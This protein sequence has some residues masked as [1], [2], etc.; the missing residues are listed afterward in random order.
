MEM[1]RMGRSSRNGKLRRSKQTVNGSFAVQDPRHHE[2]IHLRSHLREYYPGF[3]AAFAGAKGGV[4]RPEARA[5]LAAAPAPAD[6]AKLTLAQ[7][8]ALL[9]KAG[10][11]RG[12]DA[13][14]RRL[15]CAF[16]QPQMRQLPLVE[17]AMGRRA[18]ALLR[19]LDAACA[20]ADDLEQAA[21]EAFNQ[22]PDAGIITSFPGIGELTG[23]RIRLPPASPPCCDKT[24]A[25]VS[26]LHSDKQRLTAQ[27]R[28]PPGHRGPHPEP[29]RDLGERLALAQLDPD[30]QG[31]LPGVQLPPQGPDRGPGVGGWPR[32]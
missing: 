27:A 6:A 7:P 16:R 30:G 11:S 14:A 29:G 2:L 5:V 25:K 18:L 22:H 4:M 31:L 9:S 24:E 10:R 23:A 3:L 13:E 12:I 15:H 28:V 19:Q 26:H 1:F 8:R 21:I 20:S 32:P 17:Q